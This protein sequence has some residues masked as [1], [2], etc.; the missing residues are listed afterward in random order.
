MALTRR[1]IPKSET[2]NKSQ[3]PKPRIQKIGMGGLARRVRARLRLR[4]R[5]LAQVPAKRPPLPDVNVALPR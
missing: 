1:A 4:H 3:A 5:R 2:P